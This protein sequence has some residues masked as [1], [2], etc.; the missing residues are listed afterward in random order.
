VERKESPEISIATAWR[1]AVRRRLLDWYGRARRD[2]PWRRDRDPYRIW[3]SEIMLQQTRAAAAAPYYVRFLER[4]PDVASLA[5]AAE[6]EVLAAWSGLGY[7]SRARN[8][9]RAARALAAAGDFPRD[10][11]ALR[12]LPGVGDYTAAAIASIAFGL[13]H[14][15]IDGNVLRVLSRLVAERGNIG[16]AGIRR[17]LSLA[18]EK[19]LDREH[20]GEFNQALMELGATVCLPRRPRCEVCPLTRYCEARRRGIEDELP[21]KEPRGASR[22]IDKTLLVIFRNGRLLLRRRPDGD[23]RLGGFWELPELEQVP[24]VRLAGARGVVQHSITNHHYR[25]KVVAAAAARAPRGFRWVSQAQ[26]ERLPLTTASRKA[27]RLYF[28]GES[29]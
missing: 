8:L 13:P 27:L 21:V 29:H 11:A 28:A 15:A 2:L 12:R 5:A 7:Y 24:G 1:R 25:L 3:V 6:P 20:P 4:F 19:L 9:H 26:L 22:R 17:R 14:A 16:A 10:V 18:A 23:R